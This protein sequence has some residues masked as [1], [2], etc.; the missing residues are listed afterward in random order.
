MLAVR[1]AIETHY[2]FFGVRPPPT[3]QMQLDSKG[4]IIYFQGAAD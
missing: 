1:N 3:L 2:S 4:E